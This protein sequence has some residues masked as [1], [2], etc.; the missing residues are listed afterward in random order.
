MNVYHT[1]SC[2]K[3]NTSILKILDRSPTS[4]TSLQRDYKAP[5]VSPS[6][7]HSFPL[8][9]SVFFTL[10]QFLHPLSPFQLCLSLFHVFPFVLPHS[11]LICFNSPS[12]CHCYPPS[13][14][15]LLNVT[16]FRLILLKGFLMQSSTSVFE[17]LLVTGYL[18][19]GLFFDPENGGS[20]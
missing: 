16:Q 3:S 4:K 17:L 6:H 5:F 12:Y 14:L 1:P 10:K 20:M 19:G 11:F 15:L 7:H 13:F 2:S 18:R 8:P 9:Y